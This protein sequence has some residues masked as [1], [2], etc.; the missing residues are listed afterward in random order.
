MRGRW[1]TAAVAAAAVVGVVVSAQAGGVPVARA[2]GTVTVSGVVYWDQDNDG[3]QDAG[4]PGL[5]GVVVHWNAGSG[6]P[7]AVTG[8]DGSYSLSGVPTG[9][10]GKV[11]VETGW[12][13]SQCAT[14]TC[15]AGPGADNDFSVANQFVQYS[16][17]GVT[18]N[19]GGVDVG[20]LPDWPGSTAAPPAPQGGVVASN[21]VDVAARLSWVTSTCTDGTHEI[22]RVGDTYTV[23]AQILNQGTTT[24]TGIHAVLAVP[25]GDELATGV[26]AHDITLNTAATSPGVSA[27]SVGATT[28]D[29]VVPLTFAGSLVPGGE[30]RVTGKLVVRGGPGTT[31]CVSGA[32]TAACPTAEPYGAPL[33]FAVTRMDQ[34]G[35]PDSFGPGCDAATDVRACP[36]GIHDKQAEPDEVD[37][38]GHNVAASVAGSQA[39]DLTAHVVL[40]HA[41]PAGGWTWATPS[42]GGSAP[43]TRAP[44]C[45]SPAGRSPSC[46]P[47]ARLRRYQPRTSCARASRGRR[48]AG[49]RSCG[50]P[51]RDR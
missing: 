36:T 45:T 16:M 37:P 50:A 39:Y 22:C 43:R 27:M 11:V 40:L 49:S 33:M 44:A 1:R 24:L 31:G 34:S 26:P 19:R 6:T 7:K 5:S 8:G 15:P 18:S 28:A 29:D 14:L 2:A 48:R 46:C 17:T 25:D 32:P 13:R 10:S 30:I 9:G 38:V 20:L 42:R 35:D 51:A 47:R 4:E 41:A 3:V 21:D 12:F 23:S